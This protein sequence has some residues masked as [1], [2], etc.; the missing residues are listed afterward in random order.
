MTQ[1][2]I[3]TVSSEAHPP[4][5]LLTIDE[6]AQALSLSLRFVYTLVLTNQ[7]I[8]IKIGKSRRIPLVALHAFIERQMQLD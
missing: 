7:I 8:S 6:A 5:L 2:V 1:Q 3:S 4:K